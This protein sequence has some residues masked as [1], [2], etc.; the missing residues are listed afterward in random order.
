VAGASRYVLKDEGEH[1]VAAVLAVAAGTKY[2][3]VGVS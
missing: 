2:Y 1:I 3:S